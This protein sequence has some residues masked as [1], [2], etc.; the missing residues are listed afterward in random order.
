MPSNDETPNNLLAPGEAET[1]RCVCESSIMEWVS[2]C[3]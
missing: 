1:I 2:P 3:R